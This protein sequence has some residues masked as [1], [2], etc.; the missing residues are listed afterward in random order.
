VIGEPWLAGLMLKTALKW[1]FIGINVLCT[2]E[3]KLY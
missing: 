1:I 2:L 3:L